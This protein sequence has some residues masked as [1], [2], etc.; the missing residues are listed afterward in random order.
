MSEDMAD[1]CI[2]ILENVDFEDIAASI[3]GA[4]GEICFITCVKINFLFCSRGCLHA[5]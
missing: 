2:H 5:L 3:H 1:A 4:G